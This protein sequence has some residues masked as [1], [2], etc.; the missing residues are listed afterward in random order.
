MT[1]TILISTEPKLQ[2]IY[3]N[4]DLI[5]VVELPD[6]FVQDQYQSNDYRVNI[7]NS[8]DECELLAGKKDEENGY[9]KW[10]IKVNSGELETF[11][12]ALKIDRIRF[13]EE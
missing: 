8:T 5:E 13:T 9:Y 11:K 7:K 6:S 3:K 10:A 12:N 2:D 4:N 1:R